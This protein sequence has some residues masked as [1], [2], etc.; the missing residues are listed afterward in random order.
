MNSIHHPVI[1]ALPLIGALLLPKLCD[2][3]EFG[4]TQPT[5]M[6][7]SIASAQQMV[8]EVPVV[9]SAKSGPHD[10]IISTRLAAILAAS[11][12]KY[13]PAS[14]PPKRKTEENNVRQEDNPNNEILHLPK[15]VVY[16]PRPPVFRERDIHSRQGLSELAQK[17]YITRLDRALN[18][19]RLPLFGIS[20]ESRALAMYA[21]DERLQN[22]ADLDRT[23]RN[24]A[25]IDRAAGT[26][27]K[28]LA[29]ATCRRTEQIVSVNGS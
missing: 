29:D 26:D 5:D 14:K 20:L 15:Y 19:F 10:R 4:S 12:P 1:C 24:A 7:C 17:R 18:R 6:V 23:A 22:I 13:V 28:R 21:E 27:L 25:L 3:A 8:A 16:G 2:S 9:I 11:M